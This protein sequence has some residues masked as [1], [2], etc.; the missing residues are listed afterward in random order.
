M[1]ADNSDLVLLASFLQNQQAEKQNSTLRLIHDIVTGAQKDKSLLTKDLDL[2]LS[3]LK[4]KQL[5]DLKSLWGNTQYPNQT[6][7][8]MIK[9]HNSYTDELIVTENLRLIACADHIKEMKSV[10]VNPNDVNAE[11]LGINTSRR[12]AKKLPPTHLT[13]ESGANFGIDPQTGKTRTQ[14]LLYPTPIT[15]LRE[16]S[17]ALIYLPN[18]KHVDFRP[19][20][21]RGDNS[22]A[23][24]RGISMQSSSSSYTS[25][26]LNTTVCFKTA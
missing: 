25:I 15:G 17:D 12:P 14:P 18:T 11:S 8:H 20:V 7:S 1:A 23:L 22:L 13:S 5:D 3:E 26:F 2:S 21:E 24:A 10:N 16:V 9:I 6:I 4:E 19:S